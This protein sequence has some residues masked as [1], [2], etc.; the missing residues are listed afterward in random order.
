MAST[1]LNIIY[2]IL[3]S[4]PLYVR[5][6]RHVESHRPLTLNGRWGW[7]LGRDSRVVIPCGPRYRIAIESQAHPPV[8]TA[9]SGLQED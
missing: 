5:G 8:R 4:K 6:L 9:D 7:R 1:G 2:I 3:M